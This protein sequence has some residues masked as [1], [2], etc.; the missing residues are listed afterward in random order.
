MNKLELSLQEAKEYVDFRERMGLA[1]VWLKKV[2]LNREV[3]DDAAG[4]VSLHLTGGAELVEGRNAVVIGARAEV[5]VDDKI[6]MMAEY[7]GTVV[8]NGEPPTET[9]LQ[10]FR[11]HQSVFFLYGYIRSMFHHLAAEAGRTDFVLPIYNPPEILISE[12]E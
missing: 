7:Q 4:K 6:A 2:E 10:I 12:G 5:V 8:Y 11:D 3:L 1:E 9:T